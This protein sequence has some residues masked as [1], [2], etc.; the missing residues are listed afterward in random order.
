MPILMVGAAAANN[1][2]TTTTDDIHDGGKLFTAVPSRTDYMGQWVG[3]F[4]GMGNVISVWLV[5]L[6]GPI[7]HPGLTNGTRPAHSEIRG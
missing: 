2:T 6:F 4:V 1:T 7:C 3:R 5:D